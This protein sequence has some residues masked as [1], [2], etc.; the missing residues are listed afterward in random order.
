MTVDRVSSTRIKSLR[1]LLL[2]AK[3][4]PPVATGNLSQFFWGGGF[5]GA[6]GNEPCK[7]CRK[8]FFFFLHHPL[9]HSYSHTFNSHINQCLP[10]D[11]IVSL[12]YGCVYI[13]VRSSSLLVEVF[14]KIATK[15]RTYWVQSHTMYIS[16]SM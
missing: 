15:F 1:T 11:N 8:L 4:N 16:W 14:K 7:S 6:I 10:G 13:S 12:R 5:G 3:G 9:S 2:W